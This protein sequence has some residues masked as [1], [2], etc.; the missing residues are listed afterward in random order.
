MKALQGEGF[1]AGAETFVCFS[2]MTIWLINCL[3][4]TQ[5]Y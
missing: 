1:N 4:T 2:E 5:G 3:W